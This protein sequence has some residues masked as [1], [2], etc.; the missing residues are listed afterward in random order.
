MDEFARERFEISWRNGFKVLV[1]VIS[2]NCRFPPGYANPQIDG[3]T[4]RSQ[5]IV[6]KFEQGHGRRILGFTCLPVR[7]WLVL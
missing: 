6:P 5:T 2:K 3:K 1:E 7:V 4:E